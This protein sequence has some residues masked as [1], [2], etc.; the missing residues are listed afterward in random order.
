MKYLGVYL[1]EHL[2]KCH[3]SSIATKLRRANGALSK[4][5]YFVPTKILSNI[6]HTILPS[7]TRYASQIWGLHDNSVTH[8]LTL[9]NI[10]MRLL[11]FR[12]NT[13]LLMGPELPLHLC[14]LS[15]VFLN[16]L[17]KLK[18]WTFYMFINILTANCQL[19]HFGG[20]VVSCVQTMKF[21]YIFVRD[22]R[23]IGCHFGFLREF[24]CVRFILLINI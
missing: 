13:C 6:N 11:T 18:S 16:F 3:I 12:Q 19:I 10:A 22:R 9:Q 15:S 24:P 17:I 5:R 1:D 20:R 7:H 21:M 4:L 2:W 14:I 8:R 23:V